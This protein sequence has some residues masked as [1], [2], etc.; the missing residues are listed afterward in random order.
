[1]TVNTPSSW[2]WRACHHDHCHEMNLKQ[3]HKKPLILHLKEIT[4][5]EIPEDFVV[6]RDRR[7]ITLVILCEVDQVCWLLGKT[8]D[9]SSQRLEP[10]LIQIKAMF[11]LIVL[12]GLC[13]LCKTSSFPSPLILSFLF[14]L[15]PSFLMYL[16]LPSLALFQRIRLESTSS[17]KSGISVQFVFK[18]N[19]A[20]YRGTVPSFA[21]RSAEKDL[22]VTPAYLAML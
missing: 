8:F 16:S 12:I 2:R 19:G 5:L 9:S 10:P 20:D 7:E 1:M 3:T 15:G 4:N 11:N 14:H 13:V 17:I 6:F 21:I 18:E 22:L